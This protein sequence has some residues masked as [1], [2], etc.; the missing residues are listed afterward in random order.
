MLRCKT[1]YVTE[2]TATDLLLIP[3]LLLSADLWAGQVAGLADLCNPQVTMAQ[4]EHDSI[5]AM[6]AAILARAPPHFALA[7]MSMGGYVALEIVAQ[8]PTRVTRLALVD[9]SARA[10]T[11]EGRTQRLA[12]IR[13]SQFGTFTGL[14][15][16]TFG[17]WVHPERARDAELFG[18][19]KAMTMTLGRDVFVRQQTAAVN[20]TDYR[21]G[22]HKIACPT[23]VLCG[24]EDRVTPLPHA[25]EMAE[26]ITGA[27]LEVIEH[28]GHLSPLEQ[29]EAVTSVLRD[30][31]QA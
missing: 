8:A 12:L 2:S 1:D 14:S 30:W 24:R 26:A 3:G 20:R 18:R 27:R 16:L 13:Q 11:P 5:P 17:Q 28:C 15:R 10:D 29:P 7:G 19:V 31:L 22:L 6:A 23:V 25:E 9:T 4:T 21:P